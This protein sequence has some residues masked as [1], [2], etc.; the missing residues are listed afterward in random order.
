MVTRHHFSLC[1]L[2]LVVGSW[3][4]ASGQ[5]ILQFH[6]SGSIVPSNCFWHLLETMRSQTKIPAWMTYRAISSGPGQDDL[7]GNITHPFSDFASSDYPLSS[8]QYNALK[9]ASQEVVHLPVFMGA[10]GVFHSLP[11]RTEDG[12]STRTIHLNLTS[13]LVARIY[14]GEIEDWTHPDIV[15]LNPN[16]N[17]PVLLDLYGNPKDDQSYPIKVAHRTAGSSTTL[18]FTSYLHKACPEHWDA[19]LVG[20]DIVWP[21]TGSDRLF[22][23]EST[24]GLIALILNETGTI[25]YSDSGPAVDEELP[26]VALKM[27][28]TTMKEPFFLTSE[29][30]LSKDGVAAALKGIEWPSSGTDDWSGVDTVNQVEVRGSKILWIRSF[31]RRE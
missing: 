4:Y 15:E 27:Q 25:G 8:E 13:C 12:S 24:P 20:T 5:G 23:A 26:E 21:M 19:K 6:G 30:A 2:V 10:T 14:K 28:Q 9:N 1:S 17:L 3:N 18:I 29:N 11:L 31:D 16:M 7:M 22:S